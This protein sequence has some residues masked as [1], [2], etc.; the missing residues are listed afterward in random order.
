MYDTSFEIS[1]FLLSLLCLIYCL[2]GKRKQY[3]L[4]K[5]FKNILRSQ[6]FMFLMLL[7]TNMMSS[8]ASVTGVYLT[9]ITD[10][11][12][13]FLQYFFHAVYFVF[14]TTLSICFALY[15]INAT[16]RKFGKSLVALILFAL[17]YVLSELLVLT[18]PFTDLVFYME[19]SVYHRGTIMPVLYAFGVVYL[20]IGTLYFI[21]YKQAVSHADSIAIYVFI[22]I[23]AAGMLVQAL[24]SNILVEL[25]AESLSCLVIMVVLE[26][27]SGHIDTLTGAFNGLAFSETYRRLFE[28]GKPYGIMLVKVS[29]TDEL[30]NGF[31][32]RE[33]D[34]FLMQVASYLTE[35]TSTADVFS[36]RQS[37]FAVVVRDGGSTVAVL[38]EKTVK[39]FDKTWT[40]GN[41]II[42]AD[43]A[44]CALSVPR[45]VATVTD[46]ENILAAGYI[47]TKRGSF[48][49]P[50]EELIASQR[51]RL[52]EKELGDAIENGG[53]TVFYQ[54]IWSKDRKSTVAAEALIRVKDGELS[55]V[56]P[57]VYIPIAERTGMIRDIGLFVFESVCRLLK[58][59]RLNK[60]NVEYVELN[61][62]AY[63]FADDDL[64]KNFE[65]I[66]K[67]YGVPPQRI[68]L[69]ITESAVTDNSPKVVNAIGELLRLGYTFSLDDFGTGYSNLVRLIESKYLN[70][71][72][73]K[74]I[75]WDSEKKGKT[76]AMLKNLTVFIRG[77]CVD[78]VQEGVESKEQ[79][80]KV[81]SCGCNLIQG[82]Y[83]SKPVPEEEFLSYLETEAG[84]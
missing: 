12:A 32:G 1:A 28:S 38:A 19:G 44:V 5:G 46:L 33:G 84:L 74:S 20:I 30:T 78:V 67:K 2:T 36:L 75:L 24:F 61:I 16:R 65:A 14:H 50:A 76:E 42:K 81:A 72:I 8:F 57:E 21:R 66:R 64:V 49:L 83:F 45:D 53:L 10:F 47:K 25:F 73:D 39:R 9:R 63:Q 62:S 29:Q 52:L 56:S 77:F 7:I 58:S 69:E 48:V 40:C 13:S 22:I 43:A 60:T 31:G 34:Q 82:Y 27:K 51:T 54:P 41:A 71:K 70:I 4:P 59:E 80:E 79:L 18:N 37:E 6:H 11:D 23:A 55:K 26:E 3:A 35:Q 17:P 68:N 15:I